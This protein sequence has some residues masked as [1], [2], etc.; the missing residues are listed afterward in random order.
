VVE[1]H[2]ADSP[3]TIH[4]HGLLVSSAGV[5]NVPIASRQ[6]YVYEYPTRQSGTYWYHLHFGFQEQKGCYGAFV[7][8]PADERLQAEHDAVVLLGDWLHRDPAKVSEALRSGTHTGDYAPLKHTVNVPPQQTV[9][10]EFSADNPA[11]GSSTATT[12]TTSKPAWR[13]S[14]CTCCSSGPAPPALA[15]AG[16]C[17]FSRARMG[18]GRQGNRLKSAGAD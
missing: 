4:W 18:A 10:I 3:T 15:A 14:S 2:L 17:Y 8:A 13:A 11:S 6:M 1:N 7:I 16:P 5:S 9:R 12:S